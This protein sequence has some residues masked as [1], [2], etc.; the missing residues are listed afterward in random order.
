MTNA[1]VSRLRGIALG[2][3][4]AAAA[5][6]WYA[7]AWGLTKVAEGPGAAYLRGS[8]PE[9]HL[10]ALCDRPQRG[11]AYLNL[12]VQ[13]E[14][15]LKALHVKLAGRGV[16]IAA[17]IRALETPGGGVG[18]DAVDPDNR[19]LRLSCGVEQYP[20]SPD[21]P[22]APRKITHVVL[23]TPQLEKLL[24]FYEE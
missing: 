13:D 18:F 6:S 2:A 4:N 11:I 22:D 12:A 7:D 9:H 16:R 3:P 17:P 20:D 23:N 10:L 19:L 15:A 14:A 24:H 5:A 8:G 21:R 1:R